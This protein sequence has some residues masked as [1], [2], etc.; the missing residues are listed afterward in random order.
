MSI[1]LPHIHIASPSMYIYCNLATHPPN[2]PPTTTTAP[3][4][5]SFT[6]THNLAV[7]FG[8]AA[9]LQLEGLSTKKP[10]LTKYTLKPSLAVFYFSL[11]SYSSYMVNNLYIGS[12]VIA[13]YII[14]VPNKRYEWSNMYSNSNGWFAQH[15][16]SK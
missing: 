3:F 1:F 13:G 5:R 8:V 16:I 10:R 9:S 14:C 6:H 15:S 7:I 11:N 12:Y 2:H 4:I